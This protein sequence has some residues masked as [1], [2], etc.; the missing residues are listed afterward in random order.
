MQ[1]HLQSNPNTNAIINL[2]P[3]PGAAWLVST[4]WVADSARAGRL[5]DPGPY[6]LEDCASGLISV[7]ERLLGT[8]IVAVTV[9]V[10]G[11]TVTVY[12]YCYCYT[13]CT[14]YFV[15]VC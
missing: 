15:A 10:S 11:F 7:G 3:L 8:V 6:E 9:A 1:D 2:I 12:C 14:L 13:R 5:L 4:E